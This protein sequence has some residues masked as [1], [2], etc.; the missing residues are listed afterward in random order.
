M[1]PAGVEQQVP[2]GGGRNQPSDPNNWRSLGAN[3]EPEDMLPYLKRERQYVH[4]SD[5][6]RTSELG[7]I[8]YTSTT[9]TR[10]SDG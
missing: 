8:D 10:Q 2:P 7:T 9:V 4:D 1:P 5:F 3:A 6:F